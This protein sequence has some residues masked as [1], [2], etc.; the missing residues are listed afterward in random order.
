MKVLMIG[1]KISVPGGITRV[2]KNYIQAGIK[3]KVEFEYFP[4]YL[5]K[6][7][8]ANILYFIKQY[9]TLY[10]RFFLFNKNYDAAHIHMSYKG[11]FLRKKQIIKM[12]KRKNI[13]VVL[14]MHGSQFK[15]FYYNGS[16]E[17]KKEITETLDNTNTIIALGKEWKEFYE[18]ISKTKVISLDNAVFPKPIL[19][20]NNKTY[21]TSMGILSKR[22][23][24]YDLIDVVRKLDS[25]IDKR[26]KFVLA[27]NG[28]V[29]N[30]KKQIKEFEL[31][32]RF[33]LTGWIS[34]EELIEK[35]YRKSLIYILPSYNEG[36]PMSIL[37]AMS[38]GIPVV[39]TVVGSIPSV[40]TDEE[41]G[42]LVEPG[43]IKNLEEKIKHLI[44]NDEI[45]RQMGEN[46]KL[47]IDN[48][49][50]IFENM[51]KLLGIYKEVNNQ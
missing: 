34:D 9:T 30:S 31:E 51:D 24:T 42:F 26:Y 27:G 36:M 40:I 48:E 1:S 47:K 35:I 15:D 18:T 17:K 29:E 43:D 23:G 2:V 50:N 33:I 14:H 32:D 46:N 12:L 37:E 41:N 13:P 39:S 5:G 49:F 19:D 22:K 44:D 7:N 4:T 20:D 38:Y 3:E 21:I 6:S 28:E 16:N 8:F 11:S 10:I 25:K 45:R